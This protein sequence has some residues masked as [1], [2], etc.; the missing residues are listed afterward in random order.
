MLANML[1]D[2]GTIRIPLKKE[3]TGFLSQVY[4]DAVA[5][6]PDSWKDLTGETN[7]SQTRT[8]DL[9]DPKQLQ[10]AINLG[11]LSDVQVREPL[12][13][14]Q[15]LSYIGELYIGSGTPQKVRA[16]FDTGSANPWI[17]SLQGTKQMKEHQERHPFDPTLSPTYVEPKASD[18][19]WVRISFG[20]GM[21]RGY[22]V[23]DQ[24]L[25]GSPK[26]PQNQ[27]VV[28]SWK[29]GLAVEQQVFNG[30]FDAL[31]GMAYPQFAEDGVTPLFDALM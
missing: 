22:F 23:E 16:I 29:F 27:L 12:T 21:I 2:E 3:Q 15:N 28:P 5:A 19:K 30:K 1:S 4:A 18:K 11:Q 10:E 6:D 13:N 7:L 8:F 14:S 31:I 20:S 25:M 26:D 24:V 17:L 9:N